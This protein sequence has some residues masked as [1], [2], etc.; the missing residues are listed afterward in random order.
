MRVA[1]VLHLYYQDLWQEFSNYLRKSGMGEFDLYIS[2][3]R[4]AAPA[5]DTL[6]VQNHILRE[7]P[8]AHFLTVENKG[9]DIGAFLMVLKTCIT[10]GKEYDL[11]LKLHSKKSLHSCGPLYGERWRKEL[12]QPL[13]IDTCGILDFL[14]KNGQVGMIGS[15]QHISNFEGMNGPAIDD[16]KELL[17]LNTNNK[18]FVGGTM[19]WVRYPILTQYLSISKIEEILA[20][21]ESGYFTDLDTPRYTH[22]M[23]RIFGYMIAD[24]DKLIAG[25]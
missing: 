13:L 17:G 24:S 4:E 5:M 2:F 18:F 21:L 14:E 7:Y 19:F 15:K 1:V 25:I 20:K 3:T 22:A 23:E 9:L 10:F 6:K 8:E 12:Y 16:L 11:V